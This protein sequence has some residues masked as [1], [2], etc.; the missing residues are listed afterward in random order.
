MLP[1]P[2]DGESAQRCHVPGRVGL[3]LRSAAA[4]V[5]ARHVHAAFAARDLALL[6]GAVAA[7]VELVVSAERSLDRS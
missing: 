7:L 3:G 5:L 6:E 1:P 4:R 2:L